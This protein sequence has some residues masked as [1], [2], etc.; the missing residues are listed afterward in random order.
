MS[1]GFA[2]P[3]IV[4]YGFAGDQYLLT[5]EFLD[6]YDQVALNAKIVAFRGAALAGFFIDYLQGKPYFIDPQTYAFQLDRQHLLSKSKQDVLS[7]SFVKLIQTYGEPLLGLI[8]G[9]IQSIS[10]DN[11]KG[12]QSLKS[13]ADRVRRFQLE[14]LEAASEEN[15]SAKY[16]KYIEKKTGKRVRD[17]RPSMLV[18]PYFYLDLFTWEQWLEVNMRA[19]HATAKLQNDQDPPL[20]IQLVMSKDLLLQDALR[21]RIAAEYSSLSPHAYLL[22]IDDLEEQTATTEELTAL[23]ELAQALSNKAPVTNLYGGFFSVLLMRHGVFSGVVHGLEYG[24]HR[25]VV[26]V[27][28]GVASARY[29]LPAL[30]T[31]MFHRDALRIARRLGG[32][33]SV[34]AFREKV[35]DCHQCATTI[36]SDPTEDF[37]SY[38]QMAKSP[39]DGRLYPTGTTRDICARHYMWNKHVEFASKESVHDSLDA[40]ESTAASLSGAIESR[41]LAH[42]KKWSVVLRNL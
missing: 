18:A 42:A 41:L 39:K 6:T 40:M 29:Y 27:G 25:S 7:K 34:A 24:E 11:L 36:S 2:G 31:R 20:A 12:D 15:D 14:A 10:S 4:R 26:P 13:F 35:C 8:D 22:W 21:E 16:I 23:A 17:M 3:H 30:H 37:Q 38:G 28:G 32:L 1:N 5:E 33:N 19:F 9:S